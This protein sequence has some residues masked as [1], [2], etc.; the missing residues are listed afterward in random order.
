MKRTPG[1]YP[2]TAGA[3]RPKQCQS[4]TA[5]HALDPPMV[6]P[7][8]A[9]RKSQNICYKNICYKKQLETQLRQIS[10]ALDTEQP[11]TPTSTQ[12]QH[13]Q[14]RKSS[15][16]RTKTRNES[17]ASLTKELLEIQRHYASKSEI[18]TSHTSTRNESKRVNTVDDSLQITEMMSNLLEIGGHKEKEMIPPSL[19]KDYLKMSKE[20]KMME[21][22]RIHPKK[23]ESEYNRNCVAC[24]RRG[25]KLNKVFFPCE[26]KC[27][28][29]TCFLRIKFTRCPLCGQDVR[30][31]L[32]HTGD[33]QEQY[34]SWVD[35]VSLLKCQVLVVSSGTSSF[36]TS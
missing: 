2:E 11:T 10:E 27:V 1:I 21:G 18:V 28:C 19:N 34:W 22:Y 36:L 9:K 15:H 17:M 35:D 31:T 12:Y 4:W 3:A 8:R 30:I 33:E 29:N 7:S 24:S 26:H 14:K 6:P 5:L 16:S 20:Y 23:V 25:R 13:Q 32:E